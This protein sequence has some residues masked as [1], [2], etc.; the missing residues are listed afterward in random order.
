M[1]DWLISRNNFHQNFAVWM[2][3]SETGTKKEFKW[4]HNMYIL[5]IEKLLKTDIC[6]IDLY[7]LDKSIG[8]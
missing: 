2:I 6:L 7:S 5:Y 1:I 4:L 3:A 8:Q